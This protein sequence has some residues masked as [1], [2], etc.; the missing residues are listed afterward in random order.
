MKTLKELYNYLNDN[1]SPYYI[2]EKELSKII[3]KSDYKKIQQYLDGI[4]VV[5]GND[6]TF[7]I[8]ARDIRLAIK[9]ILAEKKT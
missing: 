8:P 3:S 9:A 2:T 7:S 5:M 1:I 6:G 4:T